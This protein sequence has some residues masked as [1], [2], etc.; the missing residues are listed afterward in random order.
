MM[1]HVCEA[2]AVIARVAAVVLT[3]TWLT[4]ATAQIPNRAVVVEGRVGDAGSGAPLPKAGMPDFPLKVAA[5]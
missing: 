5:L 4:D 3:L 1:R 2:T